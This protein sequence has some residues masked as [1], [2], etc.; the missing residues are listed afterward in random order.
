MSASPK[1]GAHNLHQPQVAL[2]L[3]QSEQNIVL[4]SKNVS[5]GKSLEFPTN[6]T[7]PPKDILYQNSST[8]TGV[9]QKVR[10][11]SGSG[12]ADGVGFL[13]SLDGEALTNHVLRSH[14]QARPMKL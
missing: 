3:L 9:P 13:R 12:V 1:Q 5:Q 7:A 10:F 6:L 11:G 14:G 2:K 4:V 8:A